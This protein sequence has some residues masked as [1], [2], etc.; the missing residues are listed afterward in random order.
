MHSFPCIQFLVMI[1]KVMLANKSQAI[2]QCF[3][4]SKSFQESLR[5]TWAMLGL[6]C[7]FIFNLFCLGGEGRDGG[8]KRLETGECQRAII[9]AIELIDLSIKDFFGFIEG[10]SLRSI[11]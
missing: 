10:L 1:T 6:I 2:E 8:G 11:Q 5:S 3:F 9:G 7:L 4:V